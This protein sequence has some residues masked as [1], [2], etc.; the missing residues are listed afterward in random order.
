MAS[1]TSCTSILV[2]W[3]DNSNNETGF[4]IQRSTTGLPSSYAFLANVGPNVTSYDDTGLKSRDLKTV[5]F[6]AG[7]PVRS[8]PVNSAKQAVETLSQAQFGAV[9]Q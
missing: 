6:S 1:A 5:D 3:T 4:R 7:Q 8:L 2:T 9:T